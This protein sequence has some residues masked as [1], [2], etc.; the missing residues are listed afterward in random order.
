MAEVLGCG[1]YTTAEKK[2]AG[3]T[4]DERQQ[5]PTCDV[6]E[7]TSRLKRVAWQHDPTALTVRSARVYFAYQLKLCGLKASAARSAERRTGR[8]F[9]NCYKNPFYLMNN[10]RF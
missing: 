5:E 4:D 7:R 6:L 9:V 10:S 8:P 1:S 3:K 2:N